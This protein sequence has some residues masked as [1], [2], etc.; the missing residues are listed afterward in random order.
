MGAE[1]RFLVQ[2]YREQV[3]EAATLLSTS[4][5]QATDRPYHH[6]GE[7]A[8][9]PGIKSSLAGWRFTFVRPG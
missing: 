8:P 6:V 5:W 9:S 4:L 3:K 2:V 1:D 7:R